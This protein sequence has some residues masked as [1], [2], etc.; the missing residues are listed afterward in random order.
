M[1]DEKLFCKCCKQVAS[2]KRFLKTGLC[3]NCNNYISGY[4]FEYNT[5]GKICELNHTITE[6][7]AEIIALRC[8]QEAATSL[9]NEVNKLIVAGYI[10]HHTPV[11]DA[12]RA[13]RKVSS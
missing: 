11:A 7:K 1:N 3:V 10:H 8:Y 2:G 4:M 13:L 6:L 5:D 9:A 12:L